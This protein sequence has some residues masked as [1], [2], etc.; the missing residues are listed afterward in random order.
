MQAANVRVF[1]FGDTAQAAQYVPWAKNQCNALIQIAYA[2]GL[3]YLDRHTRLGDT[4]EVVLHAAA[5]P[6]GSW[7][8]ITVSGG[9]S[10]YMDHGLL[11]LGNL[12]PLH[13]ERYNNGLLYP[14]AHLLDNTL[15]GSISY[16]AQSGATPVLGKDR[17]SAS[18]YIPG[19][20]P[21]C[22]KLKT[23]P[24]DA[25]QADRNA[26]YEELY[27]HKLQMSLCPP[28][29]YSGKLRLFVQALYGQNY[30]SGANLGYSVEILSGIPQVKLST[31]AS[32]TGDPID[33]NLANI[34]GQSHG[35]YTDS[36]GSYWLLWVTIASVTVYKMKLSPC[37]E[38]LAKWVAAQT[39]MT[40]EDKAVYEAI[41]LATAKVDTDF[42]FTKTTGLVAATYGAPIA[43][44]FSF[45]WDGSQA[46]MT[47]Q[48]QIN[49]GTGSSRFVSTRI[50]IDFNREPIEFAPSQSTKV[51]EEAARW[52]VTA[53]A[54][55]MGNWAPSYVYQHIWYPS[56]SD[57]DMQLFGDL[58][59][60]ASAGGGSGEVCSFFDKNDVIR[61]VTLSAQSALGQTVV[62]Y[63]PV[64]YSPAEG[65]YYISG[66]SG[67]YKSEF[68]AGGHE[69]TV[70][71]DGITVNT[72]GRSISSGSYSSWTT[73]GGGAFDPFT[74]SFRADSD[75]SF[76]TAELESRAGITQREQEK[77]DWLTSIGHLGDFCA[78]ATYWAWSYGTATKETSDVASGYYEEEAAI[79]FPYYDC[80]AVYVST[81]GRV[82]SVTY[83]PAT[84]R[85]SSTYVVGYKEKTD[86][87]GGSPEF[88][89]KYLGAAD[90]PLTGTKAGYTDVTTQSRINM[91]IGYGGI[92]QTTKVP[93]NSA[94]SPQKPTPS[95]GD[96]WATESS[97]VAGD[98]MVV[99]SFEIGSYPVSSGSTFV[100]AA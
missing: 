86:C 73:G 25:T 100:G 97:A 67:W 69:G 15:W 91:L 24:A 96:T 98:T 90:P 81:S 28:S 52:T 47:A 57:G 55:G 16:S 84:V 37:G 46:I 82:T 75:A 33:I 76:P 35:I 44:G 74:T 62:T 61:K 87:W 8:S 53:K 29:M 68:I 43:Y 13:P 36:E 77:T 40:R 48:K 88:E 22:A 89:S 63:D 70:V 66:Y 49:A 12:A 51:E 64:M 71:A 18:A 1:L 78:A 6:F 95:Y 4:V 26:A 30:S 50:T 3:S 60:A 42:K 39:E 41:A 2:N 56:Y 23:L 94:Y 34:G 10:L 31:I 83:N 92:K 45:K 85:S 21:G 11:A 79:I 9:C 58:D 99:G 32:I 93:T 72:I 5:G 38:S 80:S 65:S 14:S 20:A 19:T 54:E 7:V 59:V 27:A 17:P